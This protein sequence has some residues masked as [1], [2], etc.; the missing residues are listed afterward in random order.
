MPRARTSE[1]FRRQ[2]LKKFRKARL[3]T[4]PG[5]A[6]LLRILIEGGGARRGIEVGVANGH[7]AIHMG[8]GF[9]RTGGRLYSI[10]VDPASVRTARRNL[11]QVGLE[12]T[13]TV[14]EGDAC[15]VLPA[16]KGK[17]DFLFLDCWKRDYLKCLKLIEPKLKRR[18]IVAADNV[19]VYAGEMKDFLKYIH[20]SP[21]Y[22]TVTIRASMEKGDGM[23]VS[24]KLR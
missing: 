18:A 3:N 12:N 8:L 4:T 9:E 13:V 7:G 10:E 22:D 19:I 11:K 24:C 16:L 20:N 2:F 14:I 15:E 1:E 6:M 17:F 23:T 21:L 5:D